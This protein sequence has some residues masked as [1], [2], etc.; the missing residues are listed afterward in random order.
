MD[1]FQPT[2]VG[3]ILLALSRA[4]VMRDSLSRRFHCFAFLIYILVAQH[5]LFPSPV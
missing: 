2:S 4:V 1:D 3:P 5:A